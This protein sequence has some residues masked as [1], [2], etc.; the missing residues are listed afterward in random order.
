MSRGDCWGAAARLE[1][2]GTVIRTTTANA[3]VTA[4]ALALP[5]ALFM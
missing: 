2:E 3:I 1:V 5:V 4:A